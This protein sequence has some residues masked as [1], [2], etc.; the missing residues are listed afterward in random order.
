MRIA[1]GG[2]GGR[3]ELQ[4]AVSSLQARVKRPARRG[5]GRGGQRV[6]GGGEGDLEGELGQSEDD[7]V[8]GGE[9]EMRHGRLPGAA[10]QGRVGGDVRGNLDS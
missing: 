7:Q 3:H 1:L 2:E 8:G 4:Q 10:V 5:S 6:V 9:G